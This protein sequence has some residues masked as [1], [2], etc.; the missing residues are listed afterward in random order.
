MNKTKNSYFHNS[1]ASY[2]FPWGDLY[3]YENFIISEISEGSVIGESQF[4][5]AMNLTNDYFGVEKP[6]GLIS[7]KVNSYSINL[8]ELIPIARK[9]GNLRLNAVVLYSGIGYE[10]FEIEKR[11]LKFKGEVFFN[12][13]QAIDWITK[14]LQV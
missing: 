4:M 1:H 10:N 9:F 8:P 5:E 7:N 6:Y 13:D 12:L 2:N 3:F 11:L 14:E